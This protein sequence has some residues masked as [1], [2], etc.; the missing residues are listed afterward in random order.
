[1]FSKRGLKLSDA[2]AAA[3]FKP[4]GFDY[5]RIILACAVVIFHVTVINYGMQAQNIVWLGPWRCVIGLILPAFFCLSGM[6][7]AG[8]LERSPTLFGFLALRGI[9]IFPALM[10]EVIMS[11]LVLGP[12]V[13]TFTIDQ[14][15]SAPEFSAYLLNAIGW[16]HFFL[17]GVFLHNPLPGVMNGQLWTVPYELRCYVALSVLALFGL[18][19][20]RLWFLLAVIALNLALVADHLLWPILE[21]GV[22]GRILIVCFLAGVAVHLYRDRITLRA[23][24]ALASAVLAV[25]TFFTPLGAYGTPFPVAYLVAYLGT[26]NPRRLWLLQ[27]GDYSY[28]IYLYAFPIQQAVAWLGPWTHHTAISLAIAFPATAAVAAF[29]WHGLEKHALRLRGYIPVV[30]NWIALQKAAILG[31]RS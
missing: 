7:V 11:A 27:T 19:R 12:I 31:A 17:P 18:H 3:K 24:A 23:D 26:L 22:R 10:A 14:Y 25:A 16:V 20:R 6:L 15:F 30:E 1:M 28:G 9:R 5:L 2:V 4:S 13:T 8:S 21:A 29:S